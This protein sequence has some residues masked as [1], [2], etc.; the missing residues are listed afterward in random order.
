MRVAWT[1][2]GPRGERVLIVSEHGRVTSA[3]GLPL[4]RL[5]VGEARAWLSLR[6]W[7]FYP[8]G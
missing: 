7:L 2:Y 1:A 4:V 5:C 8:G 3:P 6:G